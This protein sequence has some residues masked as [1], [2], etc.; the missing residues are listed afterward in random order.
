[1]KNFYNPGARLSGQTGNIAKMKPY[2]LLQLYP[3]FKRMT[4]YYVYSFP[5][6]TLPRFSTDRLYTFPKVFFTGVI[7]HVSCVWKETLA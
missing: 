3:K 6:L 5:T 1:M 7:A 2:F 4:V